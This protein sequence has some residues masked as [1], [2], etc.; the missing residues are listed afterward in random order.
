[1]VSRS[2][3]AAGLLISEELAKILADTLR[4]YV[5]QHAADEADPGVAGG[6]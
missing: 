1:V 2:V 6:A 4:G 3:W 5:L